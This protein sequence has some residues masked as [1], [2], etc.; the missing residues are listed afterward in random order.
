MIQIVLIRCPNKFL[1]TPPAWGATNYMV[2]LHQMKAISIHAPRMG[3][4][5]IH[6]V[7]IQS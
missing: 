4:D 3:S 6:L 2:E 7:G 5:G 1:S